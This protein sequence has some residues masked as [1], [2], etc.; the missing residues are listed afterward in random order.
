[1]VAQGQSQASAVD[2]SIV[3]THCNQLNLFA[4]GTALL[5]ANKVQVTIDDS[6]QDNNQHTYLRG[7]NAAFFQLV[8]NGSTSFAIPVTFTHPFT[9]PPNV[10]CTVESGAGSTRNWNARPISVTTTGFTFFYVSATLTPSTGT[11]PT[12]KL[13]WVATEYTP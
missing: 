12:D 9:N 2:N 7:E 4:G 13:T 10:V 11:A 1:V 8:P 3:Q 5:Q 6:L